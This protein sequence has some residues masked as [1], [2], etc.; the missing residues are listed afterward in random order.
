[1]NLMCI[2]CALDVPLLFY[3]GQGQNLAFY[4]GGEFMWGCGACGSTSNRSPC[5]PALSQRCSAPI[6]SRHA[7][8]VLV[9]PRK[10]T[11]RQGGGGGVLMATVF[12]EMDYRLL[13]VVPKAMP[14]GQAG[15]GLA[16]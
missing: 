8:L 15:W 9:L 2:L 7:S 4:V 10:E 3:V 13:G 6:S 11:V 14:A 1:V 12:P 16:F 5:Y